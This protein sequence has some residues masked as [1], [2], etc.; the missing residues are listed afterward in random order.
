LEYTH[1]PW[2]SPREEGLRS[3]WDE[4]RDPA[5]SLA[6]QTLR[7]RAAKKTAH[8]G[9]AASTAAHRPPTMAGITGIGGDKFSGK[10]SDWPDTKTEIIG[11]LEACGYSYI[12]KTGTILF[13]F[14]GSGDHDH[15]EDGD[16]ER[17]YA[18]KMWPTQ[19]RSIRS[20]VTKSTLDVKCEEYQS[21][22]D[23]EKLNLRNY[24]VVEWFRRSNSRVVK[25]L[26]DH[27]LPKKEKGG[28]KSG[29]LRQLF[30]TA[31]MTSIINGDNEEID[32]ETAEHIWDMP[33]IKL[34]AD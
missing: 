32:L 18:S 21:L 17:H 28:P 14:A 24:K 1:Q 6:D 20:Q 8:T 29:Q 7:R 3:K 11:W 33:V 30:M 12:A 22:S 31:H 26:R 34:W 16:L 2:S 4:P 10:P 25:A 23:D 13:H 15:L 27:L 5:A 19:L 9:S